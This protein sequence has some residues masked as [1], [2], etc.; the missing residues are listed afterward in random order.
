MNS[1]LIPIATVI[2][3]TLLLATPPV[4]AED[5][6]S[7]TTVHVANITRTL[8]QFNNLISADGV[9]RV[10]QLGNFEK[11]PSDLPTFFL[12]YEV[13][14]KTLFTL[15]I[16]HP[17]VTGPNNLADAFELK[18]IH[19]HGGEKLGIYYFMGAGGRLN[20]KYLVSDKNKRFS[21]RML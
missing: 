2:V 21:S 20:C 14:G 7:E 8:Q 18:P 19:T 13:T 5:R 17:P 9:F 15:K 4:V 12:S 1:K 11:G 16:V 6:C 3:M 10:K